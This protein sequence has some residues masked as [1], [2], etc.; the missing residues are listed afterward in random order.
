M[1]P[2]IEQK[3]CSTCKVDKPLTEF[4]FCKHTSDNLRS[5]CKPCHKSYQSSAPGRERS[6]GY[7]KANRERIRANAQRHYTNNKA[8]ILLHNS[9]SWRSPVQRR[10]DRLKSKYGITTPEYNQILS[11][12]KGVCAIC[13]RAPGRRSL[14]VDHDHDTGKVRGLLCGRCNSALGLLGDN[15]VGVERALQYL[16]LCRVF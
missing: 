16:R 3:R 4:Y 8:R 5:Q 9:R 2:L 14:A 10:Q 6:R 11:M 15:L 7:Y 1:A 12:Q 13:G